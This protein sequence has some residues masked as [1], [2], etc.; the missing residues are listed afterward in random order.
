MK[1]WLIGKDPDAG[2]DWGQEEKGTTEDEID[3]WMAS[4]TPRTWVSWRAAI[5]AVTKSRTRLSNWSDLMWL[6]IKFP[7][8]FLALGCN[9]ALQQTWPPNS[10]LLSGSEWWSWAGKEMNTVSVHHPFIA[11]FY[12]SSSLCLLLSRHFFR[13]WMKTRSEFSHVYN[14]IFHEYCTNV[15]APPFWITRTWLVTNRCLKPDVCEK[16]LPK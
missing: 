9:G 6:N 5:H 2:R 16:I 7:V 15:E 12:T 13:S 10:L 4:L 1:S 14:R 3:G 11:P 8:W